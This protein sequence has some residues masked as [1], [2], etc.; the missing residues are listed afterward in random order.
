LLFPKR[1]FAPALGLT[2]LTAALFAYRWIILGGL[3]GYADST[4]QPLVLNFQF[5]ALEGL[6]I[7]APALTLLGYYW[8]QP[9]GFAF[10][11]MVATTAALLLVAAWCSRPGADGRSMLAFGFVWVVL[12]AAPANSM[13]FI[14]ASMANSRFLHLGAAGVAIFVA[15]LLTSLSSSRDR[16]TVTWFLSVL[17][18]LGCLHN[19]AAWRWTSQLTR[20]VLAEL[21]EL[22]PEPEKG[23]HYVFHDLPEDVRGVYFLRAGLTD[24]IRIAYGRDDLSGGRVETL[25]PAERPVIHIGWQGET[26]PVLRRIEP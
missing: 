14:N 4:G 1:R 12:A 15:V 7:R 20:Q 26:P 24:P 2:A 3:G 6:L 10:I 23:T 5:K 17:F 21:K 13:L 9:G 16:W 11:L 8:V 22:D 18:A 19:L 25:V